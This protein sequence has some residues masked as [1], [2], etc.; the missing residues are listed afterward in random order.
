MTNRAPASAAP[1][2]KRIRLDAAEYRAPGRVFLVTICTDI[3]RPWFSLHPALADI[4][5][6]TI[7]A[8]ADARWTTLHAWCVMP[9][10]VHLLM[11]DADVVGYV[12]AFKGSL[13]TRA[14]R[15][16]PNGRLWQRSFHDHAPR[17]GEGLLET[18]RYVL[19]NPV[20]AGIVAEAAEYR[21]SGSRTWPDR[22]DW[23]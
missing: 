16:D 3:R 20:R 10:H 12:R 7:V 13:T 4:T 23:G 11:E 22:M 9:D 15:I 17:S 8:I 14:Q 5:A 2:R 18:A 1:R 6:A 21:W 19:G